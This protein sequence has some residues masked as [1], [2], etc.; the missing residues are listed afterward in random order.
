M[1]SSPTEWTLDGF[2]EYFDFVHQK[3]VDHRFAWILGAGASLSSGIPL[4]GQLVDTWLADLH[5]RHDDGNSKIEE[6][7]NSENLGIDSFIYDERQRFYSEVY[8]RRFLKHPDEGY[9]YLESEILQADPS[10]GYS[11]LAAAL[12]GD[13]PQHA[14]RHNVVVTT[15][16]EGMSDSLLKLLMASLQKT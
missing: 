11:I 14:A 1:N 9:A 12:A 13:P 3:M 16:F 8:E 10:P 6:W 4:A 5:C 2:V 7:A 15:N